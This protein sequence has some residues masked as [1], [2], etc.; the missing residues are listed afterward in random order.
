M[1][2]QVEVFFTTFAQSNKDCKVWFWMP[3]TI[4]TGSGEGI[5]KV[6]GGEENIPGGKKIVVFPQQ[7]DD[8]YL[9]VCRQRT[10]KIL[11]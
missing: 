3:L 6:P 7:L 8:L 11:Q 9:D 2:N 10:D 5:A 1:S 4:D